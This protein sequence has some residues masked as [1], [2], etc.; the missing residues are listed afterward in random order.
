MTCEIC[1]K[2]GCP[3]PLECPFKH[4]LGCTC[5]HDD[6]HWD[7]TDAAHPAWWR[8]QDQAVDTFVKI[9]TRWLDE[10]GKLAG[11]GGRYSL[12]GL[13]TLRDRV[14]TLAVNE[15]CLRADLAELQ[16]ENVRLAKRRDELLE[17][18]VRL[19]RETPYP[20]EAETSARQ[21]GVLLAKLTTAERERDALR[22]E[23][24]EL[25]QRAK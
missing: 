8:G 12:P 19:T 7:A 14:R 16:A 6:F 20:D 18:I 23:R 25:R 15:G 2:P 22:I 5:V 10:P 1:T 13:N 17:T 9:F 24:D 21:V 3:G 4:P 11:E